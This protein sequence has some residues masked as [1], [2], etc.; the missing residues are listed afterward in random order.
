VSDLIE[1]AKNVAK[2]EVVQ[3]KATAGSDLQS[4]YRVGS[5]FEKKQVSW[6]RANVK[7]LAIGAAIGLVLG[8]LLHFL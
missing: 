4:A 8:W 2:A 6:L 5:A 7:P 1:S 3:L